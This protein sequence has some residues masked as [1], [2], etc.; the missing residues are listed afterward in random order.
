MPIRQEETLT[1]MKTKTP[2]VILTCSPKTDP[3]AIRAD[4][5]HTH[6]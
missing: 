6:K 3:L 1:I 4:F 5:R 2:L